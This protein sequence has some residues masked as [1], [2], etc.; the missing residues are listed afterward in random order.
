MGASDSSK[1]P[2]EGCHWPSWSPLP[3]ME[4]ITVARAV[5]ACHAPGLPFAPSIS[6]TQTTGALVKER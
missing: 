6:P 3:V 4:P 1:S 5:Q 2:V